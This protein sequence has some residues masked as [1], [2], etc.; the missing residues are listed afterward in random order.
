MPSCTMTASTWRWPI[1]HW[2]T[3]SPFAAIVFVPIAALPL[4]V[5][6]VGWDLVSVVALA[7]SCR[8]HR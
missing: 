2:F 1:G 5:A 8:H 6:R 7:Y 3:Y 4:A